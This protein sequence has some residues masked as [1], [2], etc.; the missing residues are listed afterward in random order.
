VY[1]CKQCPGG[2]AARLKNRYLGQTGLC[3]NHTQRD[4]L[5]I[6]HSAT[7][8]GGP[9]AGTSDW[10]D[11]DTP[12]CEMSGITCDAHGNVVEI[13]LQNR[14]LEGHLPDELGYL[15]FLESLDVSD[16]S[17]MGHLPSDLRW[18][19]LRH[20]DVSGNHLRGIVPP[21]LCLVEELNGNGD[22]GAFYCDRIACP[23]G[24]YSARGFRQGGHGATC[25]PCH[26]GSPFIAQKSCTQTA[27][28]SDFGF[29]QMTKDTGRGI[30]VG[31]AVG[32][33]FTLAI[34]LCCMVEY[35]KPRK[36]GVNQRRG[37]P[38]EDEE[39]DETDDYSFSSPDRLLKEYSDFAISDDGD[40]EKRNR[41]VRGSPE[42]IYGARPGVRDDTQS[43]PGG[44]GSVSSDDDRSHLSRATSRSATE[45]LNDHRGYGVSR[46]KRIQQAM[47]ESLPGELGRRTLGAASSLGASARRISSQ[48]MMA[49]K[50]TE[51]RGGYADMD[52]EVE[53]QE[54]K[55]RFCTDMELV[56]NA[57]HAS[58][59]DVASGEANDLN[60]N[61]LQK[62][63]VDLL[64]V[65]MI[66]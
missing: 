43:T 56:P 2:E 34:G 65:P 14:G 41:V 53:A 30:S 16:N 40:E 4:I 21:L 50:E 45:L 57:G 58:S 32:L 6:F 1:P 20:L 62:I 9:W 63:P 61:Q 48:R 49:T 3:A 18:T 19:S 28:D 54:I 37:Y 15:S 42:A 7:T 51:V 47:V 59:E 52:D 5:R 44:Q 27:L 29:F 11:G 13:S 26:D 23:A 33:V 64:D 66:T 60:Q 17:L 25:L 31:I 39:D 8:K 55:G 35:C 46:R 36:K 12:V 38:L 10:A 22:K 24:T